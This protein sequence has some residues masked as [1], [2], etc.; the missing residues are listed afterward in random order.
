MARIELSNANKSYDGVKVLNNLNLIVAEGELTALLGNSGSGKTTILHAIAGVI[1]LDDGEILFNNI[2]VNQ[3]P[4]EKR[5]A[6]LVDQ[7]LLLFPH[8][9]VEKNIGFGLH[10]KKT[11]KMKI[12]EKVNELIQLLEL[13]G[14]EKKYPHQLSGG[15][16]Q[17]V[18]IARALAIEP[19]VLLL[20]E[21]FSK[22][23]ISLRANMQKFVCKLQKKLNMT[24]IIVTH[25]KD[26]AMSMANRVAILS[27]GSILQYDT[28]ENIYEKPMSREVSEFFGVRNYF[29]GSITNGAFENELGIFSVKH[30][31]KN[32]ICCMIRPEEITINEN[33]IRAVVT[34]KIYCG[35]KFSC[36][37]IVNN[38]EINF[39]ANTT[40][41]FAIGDL[42]SLQLNFEEAIYLLAQHGQ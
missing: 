14:H 20:D 11:D 38:F 10:M 30:L 3:T 5:N 32:S 21:P 7:Q 40:L 6:V 42:I 13:E 23:D 4:I 17:R 33:G 29:H 24:T 34:E 31:D 26:E 28:P 27:S 9:S 36:K 16:K 18:A 35:D 37:A 8:L 1:D 39:I 12:K 15:Q 19:Y 22:L 25:D 41:S 2:Q